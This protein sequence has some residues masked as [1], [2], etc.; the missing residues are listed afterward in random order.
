ML[1]TGVSIH[2]GV[3]AVAVTRRGRFAPKKRTMEEPSTAS[4]AVFRKTPHSIGLDPT[5]MQHGTLV[6]IGTKRTS[7]SSALMSAIGGKADD[8]NDRPVQEARLVGQAALRSDQPPTG[9]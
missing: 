5:N 7:I 8:W 4:K 9:G 1:A 3:R 2:T 6:A